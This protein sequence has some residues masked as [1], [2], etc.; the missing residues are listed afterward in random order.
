MGRR[1]LTA[2]QNG[3]SGTGVSPAPL[4]RAE[5]R[6]PLVA[7]ARSTIA[8]LPTG[9][10]GWLLS[11]PRPYYNPA[12]QRYSGYTQSLVLRQDGVV[13]Q[14]L[15]QAAPSR[16]SPLRRQPSALS[17]LVVGAEP[18]THE[19]LGDHLTDARVTEALHRLAELGPVWRPPG[20]P[21]D[22][23]RDRDTPYTEP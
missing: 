8:Y 1:R 17:F 21:N 2:V 12:L 14:G 10:F 19:Y 20:S 13:V 6:R 22:W 15:V 5:S 16:V 11:G 3:I 23:P 9:M 7:G 4:V 18:V